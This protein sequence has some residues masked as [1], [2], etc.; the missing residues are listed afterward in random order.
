MPSKAQCWV[1][2]YARAREGAPRSGSQ[3]GLLTI[4][5]NSQV[6]L[7]HTHPD[8]SRLAHAAY[9]AGL[10]PGKRIRVGDY[11]C[12][13]LMLSPHG[14]GGNPAYSAA[15]VRPG[16][17]IPQQPSQDSASWLEW[18]LDEEDDRPVV[19][20][21]APPLPR[22]EDPQ[23]SSPIPFGFGVTTY[24]ERGGYATHARGGQQTL[25]GQRMAYEQG[26]RAYATRLAPASVSVYEQDE[27]TCSAPVPSPTS[28]PI[29]E[30]RVE[31]E[32]APRPARASVF[33]EEFL[34]EENFEREV[35]FVGNVLEGGVANVKRNALPSTNDS[36]GVAGTADEME[37]LRNQ[38]AEL[39]RLT[40]VS[41][42]EAERVL[43]E[44]ATHNPELTNVPNLPLEVEPVVTESAKGADV[45]LTPKT[46][47]LFSA[48]ARSQSNVSSRHE[49][50]VEVP[51]AISVASNVFKASESDAIKKA[52]QMPPP[53]VKEPVAC[54]PVV[55]A[56][57][58]KV[59]TPPSAAIPS[60]TA[61]T[62]YE[63]ETNDAWAAAVAR[64]NRS[65]EEES[66]IDDDL[67]DLADVERPQAVTIVKPSQPTR[68]KIDGA[69]AAM[70]EPE[71][72]KRESPVSL[73]K[74]ENISPSITARAAVFEGSA[75]IK[76]DDDV[77]YKTGSVAQ[78]ASIFG[79]QASLK[80]R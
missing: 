25:G 40:G 6:M 62:P 31:T 57:A 49:A 39:E 61:V 13:L 71:L 2:S 48:S 55:R 73:P 14:G 24:D 51:T 22:V 67:D 65:V 20:L 38:L 59:I 47:F 75:P 66:D 29:A 28:A 70:R 27:T 9:V 10:S 3:E 64:R 56:A 80:R 41:A 45:S 37:A 19:Q 69:T 42:D 8:G 68:V 30:R 53:I 33:E 43:N 52:S 44:N 26:S 18:F 34:D 23:P 16:D 21:R 72:V 46:D 60:V 12:E 58:Q 77:E 78:R 7:L 35:R 5:S 54:A 4:P 63:V 79:A 76:T 11:D 15:F 50:N 17:I 74:G 36:S 1:V 32:R